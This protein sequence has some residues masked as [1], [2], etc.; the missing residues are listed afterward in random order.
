MAEAALEVQAPDAREA[1]E[2]LNGTQ[3]KNDTQKIISKNWK[4]KTL[5]KSIKKAQKTKKQKELVK[6]HKTH[7]TL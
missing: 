3:K 5:H 1:F 2:L 4:H 6:N 7:K